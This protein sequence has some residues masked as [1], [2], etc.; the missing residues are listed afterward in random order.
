MLGE[1]SS[2]TCGGGKGSGEG[3]DHPGRSHRGLFARY[4]KRRTEVLNDRQIDQD[5]VVAA[6]E[7][8]RKQGLGNHEQRLA[9]NPDLCGILIVWGP[10]AAGAAQAIKNAGNRTRSRSTWP[11]TVSPAD[12]DML[13]RGLSTKNLSYR[14]DTQGEAIVNAVMSCCRSDQPWPEDTSPITRPPTGS[15][16]KPTGSTASSYQ[17]ENKAAFR[18]KIASADAPWPERA[19]FSPTDA[20]W[21]ANM[22]ALRRL[23]VSLLAA[24]SAL[25][26]C[27]KSDGWSRSFRSHC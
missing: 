25:A 15:R 11:A 7:L 27:L 12:C 5:R 19:P 4:E 13:E 6:V 22:N 16:A 10:E 24:A 26:S 3:F 17:R 20:S 9:A 1:R 23:L 8:G 2:R 18:Q 14:A 21:T